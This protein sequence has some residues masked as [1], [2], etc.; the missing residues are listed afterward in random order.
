MVV[1]QFLPGELLLT[2]IAIAITGVLSGSAPTRTTWAV[3]E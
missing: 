2:G 1:E 3:F